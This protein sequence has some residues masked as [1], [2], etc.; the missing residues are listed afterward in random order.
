MI[1]S[2][3]YGVLGG[4]AFVLL[5]RV[6]PGPAGSVVWWSFVAIQ[7]TWVSAICWRR[8]GLPFATAAMVIA[9]ANSGLLALLAMSGSAFPDLP[10]RWWIPVGF[11]LV[12]A[13]VCLL[14]ESRVHRVESAQWRDYMA[15]KNAWDI[16]VGR[17]IPNLR[18]EPK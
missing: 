5:T 16:L 4:I 17:H 3:I 18:A 15:H 9:A 8:T 14:V 13:P 1:G 11:G 6:V 12:A 10:L 7:L 2:A